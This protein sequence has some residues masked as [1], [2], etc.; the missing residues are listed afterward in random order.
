MAK[1]YALTQYAM[2]PPS[3]TKSVREQT[4]SYGAPKQGPQ[5]SLP[6]AQVGAPVPYLLGKQRVA[7]PN[8]IEYTNLRELTETEYTTE[9]RT[10]AV[11]EAN[12]PYQ[13]IDRTV[14]STITTATTKTVGYLVDTTFALALGPDV[15]LR[16]I[17]VDMNPVWQGNQGD[18][19]NGTIQGGVDFISGADF[20][21]RSGGFNQ[22]PYVG[23]STLKFEKLRAE[24]T[25]STLQLDVSR[26]VNPLGL[27]T[28]NN[29]NSDDINVATALVDVITNGWGGIGI[30]IS[31][32][33]INS[34]RDAGVVLAS[35]GN[36]CSFFI[37]DEQSGTNI[38]KALQKQARGVVFQNPSS[39][40]LQ[41]R[42]IRDKAIVAGAN[43]KSFGE[44]NLL[45]TR[46]FSKQ[47]WQNTID[48]MR[49]LYTDRTQDYSPVPVFVQNPANLSSSG[50]G[51]RTGTVDYPMAMNASLATK[52]GA[53][54]LA[55]ASSPLFGMEA[56]STRYAADL[57]PGDVVFVTRK[58]YHLYGEPMVVEKI[59]KQPITD[60][61]VVLQLVQYQTPS[62][63]DIFVAPQTPPPSIL[64]PKPQAPLACTIKT[65]PYFLTKKVF[66]TLNTM[67]TSFGVGAL[68]LPSP[69]SKYQDSFASTIT[70]KPYNT[71]VPGS[72]V[73]VKTGLNSKFPNVG[74][75]G[76][77]INVGDGF[78][79]GLLASVIVNSFLKTDIIDTY[80]ANEPGLPKVR[81]G[82]IFL[83]IN[84]E[85]LS[86][87]GATRTAEGT[88][89]LTNVR[90]SL[91]DTVA[92]SHSPGDDVFII[93]GSGSQ[94]ANAPFEIPSPYTP[95]WW[96]DSNTAIEYSQ[97]EARLVVGT[98]IGGGPWTPDFNRSQAPYRPHGTAIDGTRNRSFTTEKLASENATISWRTR[99]RV[100]LKVALYGDDPE[101]GEVGDTGEIQIHRV[102][103]RDGNNNLFDCGATSDNGNYNSLVI[104]IP[105]NAAIGPA[106]LWVQSETAKGTSFYRDEITLTILPSPAISTEDG[107]NFLINEAETRYL[108]LE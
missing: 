7:Q 30:D 37:A 80:I 64:P 73:A 66:P 28:A 97:G 20:L 87:E 79:T 52:L 46:N 104:T 75:L 14:T 19:F 47:G 107:N 63:D 81:D 29:V 92:Q 108:T 33:D 15:R 69:A 98:P 6:T 23:I 55:L 9:T 8:V 88:Y 43:L 54:D 26:V 102:F 16:G 103:I 44:T 50:R 94:V 86:F 36:F 4:T 82:V 25:S 22:T 45:Q 89:T 10:E 27:S 77:S 3:R 58:Q 68:L 32:I 105:Q 74:K 51:R 5:I 84:N 2:K 93:D 83:L 85:I 95:A 78:T 61:T 71:G 13:F 21:F 67:T 31:F 39:G 38:I 65:A 91:L 48:Q 70:N 42:L 18:N 41:F 101:P 12:G 76:T 62:S 53:R 72:R 96:I 90:R 57:L 99:S 59:R 24:R 49:V 106:Y 17:F 34:F 40:K 56:V 1:S 11:R 60:N 35:E 100:N